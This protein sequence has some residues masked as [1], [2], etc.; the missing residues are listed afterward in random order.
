MRYIIIQLFLKV[1]A[2]YIPKIG[3]NANNVRMGFT[4][5]PYNNKNTRSMPARKVMVL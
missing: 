4:K 1:F 2:P 5:P 3:N